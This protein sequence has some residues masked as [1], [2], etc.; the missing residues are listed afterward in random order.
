MSAQ[1]LKNKAREISYALIRVSFYVKRG[2]LRLELDNFNSAIRQ[3]GNM[4]ESGNDSASSLQNELPNIS[5]IFSRYPIAVSNT[6]R[7]E[8]S[9]NYKEPEYYRNNELNPLNSTNS[10]KVNSN[11]NSANSAMR[12]SAII[13]KIK[14]GIGSSNGDGVNNSTNPLA[15]KLKDLITEFPD[16][17]E[18]TLRYDL[19]RLCEQGIIEHVGNG[20]PASYYRLQ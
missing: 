7:N 6:I 13:D 8:N 2:D 3:Y 9:H 16:I 11:G 4:P 12:Q 1:F 18:R 14:Y 10:E 15:I 19:K 20:G 17:S 5:S